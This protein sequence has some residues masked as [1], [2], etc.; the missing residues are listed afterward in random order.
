MPPEAE[1][2]APVT[3]VVMPR[4]QQER[5]RLRLCCPQLEQLAFAHPVGQ[6]VAVAVLRRFYMISVS[7][8]PMGV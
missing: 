2:L 1:H 5:Y 4:R 6:L 8:G 7:T 3:G